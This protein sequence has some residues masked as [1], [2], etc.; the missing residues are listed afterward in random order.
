MNWSW[1]KDTILEV[2][3]YLFV[4]NKQGDAAAP[5]E[6]D[7]KLDDAIKKDGW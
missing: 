5:D 7:K 6:T 2:L 4:W 3:R 1:L